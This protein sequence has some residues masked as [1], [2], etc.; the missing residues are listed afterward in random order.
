MSVIFA[1]NARRAEESCSGGFTVSVNTALVSSATSDIISSAGASAPSRSEEAIVLAERAKRVVDLAGA[2]ILLLATA[3]LMAA[4]AAGIR[5]TSVGPVLFKQPR[6]TENGRV[7]ML[8]KFRSMRVDAERESGAVF[9]QDGDS[10]V[11]SLGRFL[12]KTRLD[13][14]PQLINVLKG[15]MSLVGPR[16]ERPEIAA[17]LAAK[18]HGFHR[19]LRAKAGLTGLAQ[20]IQG[21]PDDID[22]YRRKLGLDLLYIRRRG[23]LLD[24]WIAM[25]TVGV[26]ISGAG[27]R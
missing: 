15:E 24:L 10:R 19:R 20:V 11:T 9:A 25:K 1:A 8:L 3:P 5:A 14:L 2:G 12:R 7:F 23:L 6:L 17:E 26:V 21:Y 27:A 22:G 13:E 16:P 4:V 18:I